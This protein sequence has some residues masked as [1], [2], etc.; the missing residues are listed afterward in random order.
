MLNRVVHIERK[1]RSLDLQVSALERALRGH[2]GRE[3]TPAD[4]VALSGIP[5]DVAEQALL[6][7]AARTTARVRVTERGDLLFRF[8]ALT[9]RRTQAHWQGLARLWRVADRRVFGPLLA[10]VSLVLLVPTVAI[11]LGNALAVPLTTSETG[12]LWLTGIPS[13]VALL[14]TGLAFAFV[15]FAFVVLPLMALAGLA[16]AVGMIAVLVE[17]WPPT[18]PG[19]IGCLAMA[20]MS[21]AVGVPAF[22]HS[23]RGFRKLVLGEQTAVRRF[24]RLYGG[25]LFGPRAPALADDA[26]ADE[27]R[28]TSLIRARAGIL[29][30]SDLVGLFRWTPEE[31]ERALVRIFASQDHGHK[32]PPPVAK[33]RKSCLGAD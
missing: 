30:A 2:E 4:V 32:C 16:G 13:L 21:L 25:L 7:L 11:F 17:G 15:M 24:W 26:L 22:R 18:V 33:E 31:A 23:V 28:L 20:L 1:D 29:C 14:V 6:Q 9:P 3:L 8:T 12:W 10:L 5:L 19:A 27:R